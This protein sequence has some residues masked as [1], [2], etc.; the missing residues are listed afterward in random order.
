MRHQPANV[1]P[2]LPS[3]PRDWL[4][5]RPA[6]GSEIAALRR[7]GCVGS[8]RSRRD[9]PPI[10]PTTTSC[11]VRSAS[12]PFD[13]ATP[14]PAER[15]R[16]RTVE[17]EFVLFEEDAETRQYADLLAADCCRRQRQ[18]AVLLVTAH[19]IE[20]YHPVS[21]G[22]EEQ[23]D[24]TSELDPVQTHWQTQQARLPFSPSS[25]RRHRALTDRR[26]A[27]NPSSPRR[28]TNRQGTERRTA[29]PS[30]LRTI[31]SRRCIPRRPTGTTRRPR[32]SSWS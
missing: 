15:K 27:Q 32:G 29:G 9:Q 21:V 12:L 4:S 25:C 22:I 17:V 6:L 31:T 18:E 14:Q 26:N 3:L 20:P 28:G 16:A 7:T 8:P 13:R 1:S 24:R 11:S 30:G 5:R 10:V 2:D 19:E 23:V